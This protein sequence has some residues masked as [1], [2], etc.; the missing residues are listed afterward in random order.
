MRRLLLPLALILLLVLAGLT[1]FD[2]LLPQRSA[3]LGA[4]LER[5]L[6]QLKRKTLSVPG[7]E[8]AYL[9]GGSGEPLVLVH[10]FGADKDNFTRAARS[11][12]PH[13]RVIIPDL[14][15]FGES[16]KPA[17][18]TYRIEDQVQRLNQIMSALGLQRA[19]FGG[20]SM[21]GWIIAGYAAQFPDKTAS[22]WLLA[23]GGVTSAKPSPMLAAYTA[24]GVSPLV[25]RTP[26]DFVRVLDLVMADPPFLPYSMKKNLGE[27]AATDHALHSAIFVQLHDLSEPLQQIAMRVHTPSLIVWGA[28]DRVL[29]VSGAQILKDILPDTELIVMPGIGHLPMLESPG[30]S[31]RDYLAFRTRLAARP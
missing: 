28:E 8:V 20:S 24:T 30:Q 9:E 12:T 2:V 27:R 5:S 26:G 11:L 18:T 15:G 22:L 23:P 13:Y 4:G 19:H 7:F 25:A 17:G 10:G 29:D 31:A 21:G 16:S 6:S 3:A 1:A 14:P